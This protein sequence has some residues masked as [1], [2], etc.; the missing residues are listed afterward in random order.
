MNEHSIARSLA[1]K[2]LGP[3]CIFLFLLFPATGNAG[4]YLDSAH[5]DTSYGVLRS[6]ISSSYVQGNCGHCH[7]QHV[8]GKEGLLFATS[9]DATATTNPYTADDNVCFQCHRATGSVQSGGGITNENYSATFGGATAATS[10]IMEAF[11]QSGSYHNLYDLQRYIT[12]ASG[13]KSFASFPSWYNPCSGCHNVHIAKAN[14]RSTSDPTE[15][16]ISKPS[17]HENLWGDS[18][19]TEVMTTYVTSGYTYQPPYYSGGNLEPDGLSSVATTQAGKTPNYNAF[20]IDC[21]NSTNTIYSTELGRNLRTFDWTLELHGEGLAS[22]WA[23][24]AEMKAPY[25]DS[26]LGDYVLSCLDCHE[27]HGSS[28]IYLIRPNINA[29]AVSL[30]ADCS[31]CDNLCSRC[32]MAAD[33]LRTFHHQVRSGFAC[34]DCHVSIDRAAGIHPCTN[35]HYHGSSGGGYK[36]F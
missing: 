36:T 24:R 7:E 13:T 30:S 18:G 26:S 16:A 27:P 23:M 2:S 21:H 8:A 10:G 29:G 15:T 3:L 6:T 5:G 35:C 14:K 25:T 20:C 34:D 11:N 9:F 1:R 32:H 12:G 4:S 19:G 28:N 33:D 31:D 17:D 22:D